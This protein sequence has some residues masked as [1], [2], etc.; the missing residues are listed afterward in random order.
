MEFNLEPCADEAL[1]ENQ[2]LAAAEDLVGHR[3]TAVI[4]DCSGPKA[5][6]GE[7]LIVTETGCWLVL[8]PDDDGDGPY[9]TVAGAHAFSR[10]D[11]EALSDFAT[12]GEL[13][14]AGLITKAQHDYLR[15]EE[16]R[17]EDDRNALRAAALRA[18]LAKLEGANHA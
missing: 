15:A 6:G 1:P 12:A 3:I 9:I 8:R 7:M 14:A 16:K 18:E 13:L 10:T 4:P 2:R 5:R 11:A 17:Q